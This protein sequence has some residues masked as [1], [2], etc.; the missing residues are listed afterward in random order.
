[1][2]YLL[3]SLL[4]VMLITGLAMPLDAFA[5]VVSPK[6]QK[7]I[8]ISND[9]VFCKANLFKII[10]KSTG[11]ASCVTPET[12][13]KLVTKGWAKSI[14][15]AKLDQ[16]IQAIKDRV[17]IGTVT[18]QAVVKQT[19]SPKIASTNPAVDNYHVVFQVCANEKTIRLPEVIVSSDSETRF[20]K[21]VDRIPANTCEVNAAKI[22]AANKDT[23]QLKL[24][25]KGGVT[26]K[27]TELENKVNT[28]TEQLNA[29][30]S[31]LSTRI[32]QAEIKSD[33]KPDEKRLAKIADLRSQLHDA[34]SELNR[35]LFAHNMIP[36]VKAGDLKVPT[37]VA[38][39]PLQGIV[40]NKL[41]A[42]PQLVQEGG[43]DVVFEICASDQIVRIPSVLVSSSI[44]SKTVRLADKI[45]PNS[46]Q[47]SGTKIQAASADG[48]TVTEGETIK[49]STTASSLEQKI[50][51]LT[52]L[53]Q[54]EKQALKDLTHLNPRPADFEAQLSTITNKIIDTR[55][56]ITL[57][58]LQLYN[59]LNEVFQN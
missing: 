22:K 50:T 49:K 35:Y 23:I 55:A 19:V 26:A 1:M 20:V 52:K 14:D 29:E 25:N 46:C 38:G 54:A 48:I 7:S 31:T 33:F 11:A 42:T 57:T 3:S 47:V 2:K 53:L 24:V 21:L 36:K 18:K 51:D 17:S 13:K 39:T 6:K 59:F 44:E 45:S 40:V 12:A 16:F 27:L 30:R 32:A 34:K 5:D 58:K 4:I 10:K 37:S 43:F 8:G 41:S 15:S 9:K 56:E 28:L